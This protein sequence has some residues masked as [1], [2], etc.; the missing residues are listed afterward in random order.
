MDCGIGIRLKATYVCSPSRHTYAAAYYIRMQQLITYVCGNPLH[1][2]VASG[3]IL[4]RLKN[5]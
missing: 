2:Y 1:T 4:I 3:R 5:D